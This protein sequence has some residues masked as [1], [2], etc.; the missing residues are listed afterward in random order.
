[1]SGGLYEAQDFAAFWERYLA[2]HRHPA[3]RWIHAVATT[4]ALALIGTALLTGRW[5]LL[6]LAPIVDH[7]LSQASH[8][9]I[10]GNRT[11]PMR[12]PLWHVRAELGMWW[13]TLSGRSPDPGGGPDGR[14]R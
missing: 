12:R 13:M 14:T 2:L 11:Q 5:G 7:L 8:R 10:E 6:V 4:C 9:L 1:M 3:T